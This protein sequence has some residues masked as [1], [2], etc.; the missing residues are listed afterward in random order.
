MRIRIFLSIL[1]RLIF[2]GIGEAVG[3]DG[4]HSLEVASLYYEG[5][6]RRDQKLDIRKYD[7][8]FRGSY[9]LRIFERELAKL[10]KLMGD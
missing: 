8:L 2:A 5:K 3:P 6:V 4:L 10:L 1:A 7:D 9:M